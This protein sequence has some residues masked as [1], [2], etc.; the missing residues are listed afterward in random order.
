[1]DRGVGTIGA[2]YDNQELRIFDVWNDNLIYILETLWK[3]SLL[4][5]CNGRKIFQVG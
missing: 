1:M 3:K 2:V 4:G 5:G